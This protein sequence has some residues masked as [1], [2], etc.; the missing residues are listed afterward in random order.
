M[1]A[2][3]TAQK[4]QDARQQNFEALMKALTKAKKQ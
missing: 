1:T 2:E 3:Q 4:I